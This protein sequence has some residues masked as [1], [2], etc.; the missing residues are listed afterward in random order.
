MCTSS[1]LWRRNSSSTDTP[2]TISS[3][4]DIT[5]YSKM[6]FLHICLTL[7]PYISEADTHSH[8]LINLCLTLSQYLSL[9]DTLREPSEEFRVINA[10]NSDK[11]R[12]VTTSKMKMKK[13]KNFINVSSKK[14]FSWRI[15][16]GSVGF[17][18]TRLIFTLA[19]WLQFFFYVCM[20]W[21]FIC[22]I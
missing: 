2:L 17:G 15:F 1:D 13:K 21:G 14:Y 20:H 8:Q 6:R 3:H 9:S 7:L 22:S 11:K 12:T 4:V 5:S 18:E 19:P 16:V 10:W